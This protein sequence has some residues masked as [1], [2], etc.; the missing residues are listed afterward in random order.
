MGAKIVKGDPFKG[1]TF[2]S[3]MFSAN[4]FEPRD[5]DTGR[6]AAA[7]ALLASVRSETGVDLSISTAKKDRPLSRDEWDFMLSQL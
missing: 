3:K 6:T 1:P 5:E 4:S 2:I 7:S